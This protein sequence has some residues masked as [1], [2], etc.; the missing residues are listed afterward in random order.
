[1]YLWLELAFSMR[2]PNCYDLTGVPLCRI[3]HR[4]WLGKKGHKKTDQTC[5]C[6]KIERE[7]IWSLTVVQGSG[8]YKNY[9]EWLFFLTSVHFDLKTSKG[10]ASCTLGRGV[11][12]EGRNLIKWGLQKV[13]MEGLNWDW[14][15]EINEI[16]RKKIFLWTF[17]NF[18]FC[19]HWWK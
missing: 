7:R 17:V 15:K 11:C 3:R 5:I 6:W 14:R 4:C 9:D 2:H 8:V 1:M 13:P 10:L 19:K 12:R 16:S 18:Y